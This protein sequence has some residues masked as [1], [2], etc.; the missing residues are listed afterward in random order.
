MDSSPLRIAEAVDNPKASAWD[1]IGDLYWNAGYNGGPGER[2]VDLYLEGVGQFSKVAVLGASTRALIEGAV[3]R[4]AMVHVIDFSPVMIEVMRPRVDPRRCVFIQHDVTRSPPAYLRGMFDL[5][6]ADRLINRFAAHEMQ[7]AFYTLLDLMALGAVCRSSIRLGLYQRD[8]PLIEEGRRRGN[9]RD[10]F[11]ESTMTID[12]GRAGD[13][14]DAMMP[15]HGRIPR[16]AL[17]AFY[18]LRGAEKRLS[19]GDLESLIANTKIGDRQLVI[20]NTQPLPDTADDT[21]YVFRAESI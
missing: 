15:D 5:I 11:D 18:R 9:V 14:L 7:P 10:F 1:V 8:L 4:G 2:D 12:Y 19:H 16:S 17:L 13:I 3:A 21:L 6:V 20:S